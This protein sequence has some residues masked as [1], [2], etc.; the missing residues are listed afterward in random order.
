MSKQ[1]DAPVVVVASPTAELAKAVAEQVKKPD[2]PA[3]AEAP[4]PKVSQHTVVVDGVELAYTATAGTLSL[5]DDEDKETARVFYVAYTLDGVEQKAER[6]VTFAF[7]GGPGSSSVWLHLGVLGPRR[8]PFEG[9]TLPK[10]PYGVVANPYSLLDVTDLVFI[11]PVSTGF[12]RVAKGQEASQFHGVKGDIES[13]GEFIRLYCSRNGRWSSPKFL[14]GES[15]GTTR[16]AGL[17]EHLQSRHGMFLNGLLLMSSAIQFATLLFDPG[18]DLP[19]SLV[20][21]SYAATAWYHGRLPDFPELA[22]LLEQAEAFALGEYATALLLGDRLQDPAAVAAR[23]SALTGLS[24]EYLLRCNLRPDLLRF[25]RELL[26]DER[27][28]VG[29]L[30]SRFKGIA[31]DAAGERIPYDPSMSAVMGPYSAALNQYLRQDLGYEDDSVYEILTRKVRPWKFDDAD[32]SYLD[33]SPQLRDAMN[34]NPHLKVF[35]ANGYYDLATPYMAARHTMSHLGLEPE[36]RANIELTY[37][38]AGHMMYIHP[39]SLEQ[40][41]GDLVDFIGRCLS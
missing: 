15:Y 2:A 1:K 27:R 28:I 3:E 38:E 40:L 30:D 6:P 19:Y 26:R 4:A 39:P 16:A 12:S 13:V 11:D 23:M 33:L 21:P 29:R 32:N 14:S 20:L 22:P 7:N 18:N 8:V 36:R 25:A 9:D 35:L 24:V 37:Y 5:K 34:Q 10:P 31:P 17:A 41:R